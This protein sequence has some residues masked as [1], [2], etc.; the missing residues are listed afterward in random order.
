[1]LTLQI[2]CDII[3]LEVIKMYFDRNQLNETY[4][5]HE[6]TLSIVLKTA[7]KITQPMTKELEECIERILEK[8]KD[9]DNAECIDLIELEKM[10]IKIPA[11]CLFIQTKINEYAIK[12]EIEHIFVNSEVVAEFEKIKSEK[13]EARE[14]MKRA[15][16]KCLDDRLVEE[17]NKQ[18]CIN[19]RD[20]IIRADKVYEGIKKIME[21]KMRENEYNRKSQKFN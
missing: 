13:G 9:I 8:Y 18:I 19:L 1:M 4:K 2:K 14:K 15:E 21:V 12:S 6:E 7:N 20:V 16:A 3:Y 10:V 17:L 11:L 5:K